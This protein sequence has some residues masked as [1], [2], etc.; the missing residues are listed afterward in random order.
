MHSR[1]INGWHALE[2]QYWCN[3]FGKDKSHTSISNPSTKQEP[4]DP[5]QSFTKESPHAKKEKKDNKQPTQPMN[6]IKEHQPDPCW[7]IWATR[8]KC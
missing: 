7:Q 1:L 5:I 8:N 3:I 4:L 6:K 2:E